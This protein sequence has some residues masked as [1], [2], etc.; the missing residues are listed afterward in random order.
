M[1]PL[2]ATLRTKKRYVAFEAITLENPNQNEVFN[3]I[4]N[5]LLQLEGSK[6]YGESELTMPIY[7]TKTKRGI[8]KVGNK[9]SKAL[10]ASTVFINQ[11]N[12]KPVIIKT[13]KTSGMIH[14][15]KT[16]VEG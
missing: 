11:I 1:R 7:N 3:T 6:K 16:L 14:K 9:H 12:N 4:G 10:I 8:L 2:L 15:M 5:N 13:L